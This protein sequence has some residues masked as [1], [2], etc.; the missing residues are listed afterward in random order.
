M[1]DL[2]LFLLSV[3]ITKDNIIDDVVSLIRGGT[4]KYAFELKEK[5]LKGAKTVDVTDFVNWSSS[6]TDAPVLINQKVRI[7]YFQVENFIFY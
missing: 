7:V 3:N 2:H 4:K 5:L 6:L 1:L